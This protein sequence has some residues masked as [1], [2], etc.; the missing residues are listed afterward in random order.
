MW[1]NGKLHQLIL[2]GLTGEKEPHVPKAALMSPLLR[3]HAHSDST[4]VDKDAEL[5][6]SDAKKFL[7]LVSVLLAAESPVLPQSLTA[8]CY[9][10]VYPG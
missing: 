9:C 1:P 6:Y 8:L 5:Q 7:P 3:S 4:D 10:Q 2:S